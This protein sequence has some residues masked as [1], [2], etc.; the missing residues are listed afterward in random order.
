MA[1]Y[2]GAEFCSFC[3][4]LGLFIPNHRIFIIKDA[5]WYILTHLKPMKCFIIHDCQFFLVFRNCTSWGSPGRANWGCEIFGG[6][7]CWSECKRWGEVTCAQYHVYVLVVSSQN[8]VRG[9]FCIVQI[10]SVIIPA[11]PVPD[12][13]GG[14]KRGLKRPPYRGLERKQ[15]LKMSNPL[16]DEYKH[17]IP[18]LFLQRK[19]QCLESTVCRFSHESRTPIRVERQ[20]P[21]HWYKTQLRQQNKA[22]DSLP[23]RPPLNNHA[24]SRKIFWDHFAAALIQF[25]L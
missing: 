24:A 20:A 1:S 23:L 7:W 16:H 17:T 5:N 3:E 9:I 8:S 15:C 13:L 6:K 11:C 4:F 14:I 19:G 25:W 18:C 12:Y 2:D 21:N 10:L 22:P